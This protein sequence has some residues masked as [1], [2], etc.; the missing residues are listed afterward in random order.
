MSGALSEYVLGDTIIGSATSEVRLDEN[1]TWYNGSYVDSE[2]DYTIRGG[3]DRGLFS[4]SGIG[5]FDVTTRSVLVSKEK[6]LV[7]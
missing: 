7:S 3:K 2:L 4:V 5:M 6:D 1:S